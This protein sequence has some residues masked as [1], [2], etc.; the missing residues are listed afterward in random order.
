MGDNK[1]MQNKIKFWLLWHGIGVVWWCDVG[2]LFGKCEK[3]ELNSVQL[4]SC[5]YDGGIRGGRGG[6]GL[7]EL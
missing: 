3:K 6:G 4:I 7:N 1:Q 5:L 2:D